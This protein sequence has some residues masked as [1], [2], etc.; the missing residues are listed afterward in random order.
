MTTD[1]QPPGLAAR[2]EAL[3]QLLYLIPDREREAVAVRLLTEITAAATVPHYEARVAR[4]LDI[5]EAHRR[6]RNVRGCTGCRWKAARPGYAS[7]PEDT[8]RRHA[9][10]NEHLARLIVEAVT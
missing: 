4:A 7:D 3:G 2:A 5:I 9:D 6:V 1:V 8:L 10:F